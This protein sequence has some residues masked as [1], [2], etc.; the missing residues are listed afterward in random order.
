MNI[1]DVIFPRQCVLC[2]RINNLIC[3]RCLKK[4]IKTLP[5]CGVC[6]K[7]STNYLTHTRCQRELPY[8]IQHIY[9]GWYKTV[10][11]ERVF[12]TYKENEIY[13]HYTYL[14][15]ELIREKKLED[16]I[17]SSMIYPIKADCKKDLGLN[18]HLARRVASLYKPKRR[19]KILFIGENC[20]T[21]SQSYGIKIPTT[22]N[23]KEVNVLTIFT[24]STKERSHHHQ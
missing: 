23:T 9:T 1:V 13:E 21:S 19:K 3:T 6:L 4:L 7:V 10:D 12:A 16:L 8:P 5:T 11:R 15:S 18:F 17:R 14:I 24:T 2:S 22:S 20:V